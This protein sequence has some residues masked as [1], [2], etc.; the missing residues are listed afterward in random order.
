MRGLY[1]GF[2]ELPLR[3]SVLGAPRGTHQRALAEV[4]EEV[5]EL[6]EALRLM[7]HRRPW[8]GGLCWCAVAPF[9]DGTTKAWRHDTRCTEIMEL[10]D[11][12]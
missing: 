5:D 9:D 2:G 6:R 12:E 8:D 7:A 1:G 4:F 10:L 11:V 3:E